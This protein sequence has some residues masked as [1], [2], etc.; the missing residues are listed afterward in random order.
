YAAMVLVA[1]AAT[2]GGVALTFRVL[3]TYQGTGVQPTVVGTPVAD[4]ALIFA[5]VRARLPLPRQRAQ[6][7]S[8][9]AQSGQG[10]GVTV[11]L[12]TVGDGPTALKAPAGEVLG[13]LSWR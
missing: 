10:G 12:P 2:G 4:D 13:T 1:V 9:V 5:D 3:D 8:L 11:L 7:Y 6:F